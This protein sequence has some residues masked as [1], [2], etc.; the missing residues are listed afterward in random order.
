MGDIM[1]GR[2]LLNVKRHVQRPSE[3]A[4]AAV[5]ALASFYDD[6][7]TYNEV[8][9]MIPKRKRRNGLYTS[10]QAR[11]LNRLGY[12]KVTVVTADLEM[13][14]FTWADLSKEAL[15]CKLKRLRA[16]YGR[17]GSENKEIVHD[18]IEWLEAEGYD[19]QLRIDQDFPR[20]I[21]RSLDSGRPIGASFNWTAL[22]KFSKSGKKGSLDGDIKGEPEHH[23]V[24][25]RGYDDKG[26]F[27]VDSHS[28]SYKGRWKKYQN[29]Y[30]KVSWEKFLVNAHAGDLILLG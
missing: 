4:I 18:M 30:Y 3:C 2:V 25:L 22:H 21:R 1:E 26:V 24:V 19:N 13:V 14:D 8:R 11:L 28:S 23:A 29:G 5:T 15:L 9:T 6:D 16:Y 10:Q 7:I 12:T 17:A 20:Y 27:V